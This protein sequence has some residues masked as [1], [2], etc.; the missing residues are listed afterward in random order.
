MS[1]RRGLVGAEIR[2]WRGPQGHRAPTINLRH[3]RLTCAILVWR[4]G[5]CAADGRCPRGCAK[6]HMNIGEEEDCVD[7]GLFSISPFILLRWKSQLDKEIIV[8]GTTRDLL[9]SIP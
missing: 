1:G 2:L 9:F 4:S 7:G 8:H 3:A 5:W 6:R